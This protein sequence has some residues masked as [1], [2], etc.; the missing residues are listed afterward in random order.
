MLAGP[1]FM[2]VV[3]GATTAF[4]SEVARAVNVEAVVTCGELFEANS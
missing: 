1:A 2:P 4:T 3:A